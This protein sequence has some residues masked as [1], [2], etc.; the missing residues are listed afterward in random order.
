MPPRW[1]AWSHL[2]SVQFDHER[3]PKMRQVRLTTPS[4]TPGVLARIGISGVEV[5]CL[6]VSVVAGL[7]TVNLKRT[8][9]K[10]A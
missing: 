4:P 8:P 9:A 5:E 10:V 6:I 1:N 7:L 3:G 2:Q